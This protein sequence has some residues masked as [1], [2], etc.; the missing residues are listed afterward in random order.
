MA[1]LESLASFKTA[2]ADAFAGFYYFYRLLEHDADQ[3]VSRYAISDFCCSSF[4]G[5]NAA[6]LAIFWL[7][8]FQLLYHF[9]FCFMFWLVYIKM[10]K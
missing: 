2:G 8:R 3:P 4:A 10:K 5:V 6:I 1:S 7:W 9:G